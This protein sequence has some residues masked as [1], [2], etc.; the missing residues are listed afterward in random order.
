[1]L[2]NPGFEPKYAPASGPQTLDLDTFDRIFVIGAG[3]GIQRMA[4]AFEHALGDRL[5]GGVVIDKH[6]QDLEC[7][8]IK[9]VY[10]AHPLPDEGCLDGCRQILDIARTL[11]PR[12]LVFTLAGNGVSS[13]LTLP[14]EG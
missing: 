3:K 10:G 11:T 9:V 6:G 12:D 2:D 7:T 8:R 1:M 14:V 5:T 4:L 13:L